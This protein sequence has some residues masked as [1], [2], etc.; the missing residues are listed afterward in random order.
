MCRIHRTFLVCA[1]CNL[2][3]ELLPEAST[4]AHVIEKYDTLR[5][6]I[7][8]EQTSKVIRD[9]QCTQCE[10]EQGKSEQTSQVIQ[11]RQYQDFE[12][13]QWEREFVAKHGLPTIED[14]EAEALLNRSEHWGRFSHVGESPE[15]FDADN[16]S[17][18]F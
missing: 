10:H 1:T 18:N 7:K 14:E 4:C 8:I 11:N 13:E 15:N 16:I 6:K 17:L 9:I 5:C 3:S 12:V 2:R